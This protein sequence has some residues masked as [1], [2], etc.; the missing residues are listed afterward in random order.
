MYYLFYVLIAAPLITIVDLIYKYGLN[1]KID[2][3]IFT[4]I[5]LVLSGIL[6]FSYLCYN[7]IYNPKNLKFIDKSSIFYSFIIA[8]LCLIGYISYFEAIKLS[9]SPEIVRTMFSALLI[10]LI[11][12]FSIYKHNYLNLH[13]Y[14]GIIL[15]LFGMF[16]AYNKNLKLF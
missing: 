1:K 3:T 9:P 15:V 2:I 10:I 11:M 14:I 13:Q 12:L 4:C 7:F 8:I 6:A 16:L 5:Y